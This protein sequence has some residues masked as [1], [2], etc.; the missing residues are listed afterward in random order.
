MNGFFYTL[1][2]KISFKLHFLGLIVITM[3][4]VLFKT[5]EE[6]ILCPLSSAFFFRFLTREAKCKRSNF[7]YNC[8]KIETGI[9]SLC[10]KRFCAV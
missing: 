9:I 7:T 5:G 8:M 2:F 3:I 1:S 6:R 4:F 10:S